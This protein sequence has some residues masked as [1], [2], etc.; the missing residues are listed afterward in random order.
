[1]EEIN[2]KKETRNKVIS[3]IIV[4]ILAFIASFIYQNFN[5]LTLNKEKRVESSLDNISYNC[6]QEKDGELYKT[7]DD[8]SITI[9]DNDIFI[10]KLLLNYETDSNYTWT[11]NYQGKDY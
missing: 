7:C 9:K 3:F 8:M 1:M 4:L 5:I 6:F 2:M 11:I 10:N